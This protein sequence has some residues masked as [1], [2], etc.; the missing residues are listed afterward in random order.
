[1]HAQQGWEMLISQGRGVKASQAIMAHQG[2]DTL[3]GATKEGVDNTR[4]VN[5]TWSSDGLLKLL[6][7]PFDGMVSTEVVPRILSSASGNQQGAIT[8]ATTGHNAYP[9]QFYTRS[10]KLR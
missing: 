9:T 10:S 4:A 8:G 3:I 2:S 1:M 6:N 7:L 5:G